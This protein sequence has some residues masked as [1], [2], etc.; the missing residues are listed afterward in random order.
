[1][2]RSNRLLMATTYACTPGEDA[3]VVG[4]KNCSAW[5]RFKV[6]G[7]K[8]E[9]DVRSE[10]WYSHYRHSVFATIANAKVLGCDR[11]RLVQVKPPLECPRTNLEVPALMVD[12][13]DAYRQKRAPFFDHAGVERI[14]YDSITTCQ[15]SKDELADMLAVYSDKG[16]CAIVTSCAG[17]HFEDVEGIVATHNLT[18]GRRKLQKVLI[19][20][21]TA[22][23]MYKNPS[24]D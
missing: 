17:P 23:D 7:K 4:T 12:I 19:G 22:G 16:D 8:R 21:A 9:I 1:M 3:K 14:T 10:R 18:A 11:T 5:E 13:Y 2:F 20:W 6:T 24:R 15:V